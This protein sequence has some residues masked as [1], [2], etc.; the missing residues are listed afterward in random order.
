M[1]RRDFA[2][3]SAAAFTIL[4][5]AVLRGQVKDK[6]RAG[7]VGCGGRGTQA[8]NDTLT[9][10]PNVEIVA[11]A[12]VFEDKLET[13]LRALRENPR[14]APIA[15]RVNVDAEHRFVG[16]DAFKKLVNSDLDIVMLATPPGY[17]PE[18]FEA[19]VNAKKHIFCEKPI[20]TDPVGVR[21]FL[22]AAKK[23]E[24][25]KL[26]VVSGAQ[27]HADKPYVETVR[28]IHDGAIG[29]VVGLISRYLSGPVM[30]AKERDAKWGDMEWEHRDWYSF[31]WIC[32]DQIVEQHYHNID[33][34]NWVMNAH[35]VRVVAS[36]GAAWRPR[37]ELYGNIY[38]HLASDFVY[39][40]GVHLS[41]T[42]RQ[43]PKGCYSQVDDLIVGTKGTSTGLDR[44]T[45]GLN[46]YVQE[47]IDL[48]NSILGKGP[49]QNQ[50]TSIAE[51]TMTCIMAREA[52]Y[53][54][55]EI[56]WDMIMKSELDLQP[57]Q[58][59]YDVKMEPPPLPVPGQYKFV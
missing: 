7:L 41:S 6:L 34:M 22:A 37:T 57:K 24:E 33:F 55:L 12:D 19:A 52:G 48:V 28:Q 1:T 26:T 29:D 20:A 13:S 31:I 15:A 36:G 5:P 53:S 9:G 51:A 14:N 16:F 44:G 45:K 8:I 27:R 21:R 4:R 59:G 54:G 18:H 40:N 42:C 46:P 2:A 3:A 25:L 35:P 47:H 32:G 50:A 30:H 10:N 17:R 49:Y 11:M 43:Y 39:P 23:S 56:T 38:D 58:F